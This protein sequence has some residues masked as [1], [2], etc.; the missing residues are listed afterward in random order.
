MMDEQSFAEGR[1]RPTRRLDDFDPSDPSDPSELSFRP[2]LPLSGSESPLVMV[3]DD[4]PAVRRVVEFS[5]ARAGIPTISY[6]DGLDAIA[7]LQSGKVA[8]PRILLL[9]IGLP[10][11]NGYELARMFRSHDDFHDTQI[12]MLSG[13][14]GVVN[15]IYSRLSGASGFIAK[16]FR[17]R[18]FVKRIRIALGLEWPLD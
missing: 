2:D 13:H 16:P 6:A 14:D 7:A 18:E 4:S 1:A 15:Q 10:R 5:L 17:S 8:P 3:I 12:I 11:M 9:D